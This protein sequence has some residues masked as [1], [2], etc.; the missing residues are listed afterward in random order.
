MRTD[1][2]LS[3]KKDFDHIYQTGKKHIAK[4]ILLAYIA[5]NQT[6]HN[7]TAFVVSK[8]IGNAVQRNKRRRQTKAA[9]GLIKDKI[10]QGFDILFLALKQEKN[11]S[12]QQIAEAVNIALQKAGILIKNE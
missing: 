1:E 4:G 8:K 6:D 12:Y 10:S 5:K 11:A 7:R 3:K 2:S 9:Y